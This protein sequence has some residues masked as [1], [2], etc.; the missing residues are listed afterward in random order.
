MHRIR[1]GL[2]G[3]GIIVRNAHL[4]ALRSLSDQF[5]VV[6]VC[7][8]H[9]TNAES[10]SKE[11][12]GIDVC[13][14]AEEILARSDIDAVD[15]ATPIA[16][17]APLAEMAAAADK[18]V[19]LEKPIAARIE[20]APAVAS[21]PARFGIT[22]LVAET[23]R[24]FPGY[25]LGAASVESGD[26]GEPRFLHWDNMS[27]M[28]SDSAYSQTAWRQRPEHIGGYLSDGGVHA[29]AALQMVAGPVSAVHALTA[30]FNPELLGAVDTMLVNLSFVS[31]LVGNLTF[32]VGAPEV[33]PQPLTVYGTEGRMYVEPNRVT[34]VRETE[35]KAFEMQD[36]D[37][38]V[39]EFRDFYDAV[40]SGKAPRTSPQDAVQDLAIVDAALRS[41]QTGD[42]VR[43]R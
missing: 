35:T 10:L 5:Q 32:S 22:L 21:L 41:A 6:A 13:D 2:I 28:A 36:Q 4:P 18:H 43:L 16:L 24:Y 23:N 7:A 42:V 33:Q 19:F 15:I 3:A 40:V 14:N 25:R 39:E 37:P 27:P 31:G 8:G 29:A 20:D 9:R 30:S 26:I 34:I 17:N 1:L 38:F 11:M 12:G